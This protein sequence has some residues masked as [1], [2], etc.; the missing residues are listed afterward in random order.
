MA[1]KR[2]HIDVYG[3]VQGVGFRPFIYRIAH[4]Y[5]LV[6]WVLNHSL[7]VS[8]EVQGAKN[9]IDNFI[10]A[11]TQESPP[12]SQV[13]DVAF[14]EL[15][16]FSSHDIIEQYQHKFSI[17]QSQHSGFDDNNA[18]PKLSTHIPADFGL[19]QACLNDIQDVKSRYYRY[20]FTNCT[21]CGPRLSIIKKLPYDRKQTSM[22]SFT[23][24]ETCQTAYD[25]PLDRRYHAQPVACPQCGPQINWVTLNSNTADELKTDQESVFTY[26]VEAIESG[27]VVA[28]KGIGGFHLVCDAT[29]STAVDTLRKIK[30]RPKK[31]LAVMVKDSQQAQR[32]VTINEGELTLLES[33]ERPIVLLG[34]VS[35]SLDSLDLVKAEM[36]GNIAENVPYLGVMLPYTPLHYL[37]FDYL[38]KPLVFTSAN[39]SN[40]PILA[41]GCDVI[42]AFG[43]QLAGIIDHSRQIINACD[44][45]VVHFAGEQRQMLRLGRGYAP[46]YFSLP[47]HLHRPTLAVGAQQKVTFALAA[48]NQAMV[49]PYIGDLSNIEMQQFFQDQVTDLTEL[50]QINVAHYVCDK[51]PRYVTHQWAKEQETGQKHQIETIQH[52]HAHVLSVMAEYQLKEPVLGFSFDGTGLGDND[53]LWGG[54]VLIADTQRYQHCASLKPFRLISGE[55]AIK[56]PARL[57]FSLLLEYFEFEQIQAMHLAV[58]EQLKPNQLENWHILWKKGINSPYTSSMGRFIDAYCALLT[59]LDTVH[60]EGESGL[61]LEQLVLNGSADNIADQSTNPT[62]ALFKLDSS[63]LTRSQI[64]FYPLL[65]KALSYIS[66]D[67]IRVEESPIDM[68][69]QSTLAKLLFAQLADLVMTLSKQHPQIPVVLSGGVFQNRVLMD[70]IAKTFKAENRNYYASKTLPLNDGGICAGQLWYAAHQSQLIK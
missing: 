46:Y 66:P 9:D 18:E 39:H 57:L 35:Q 59:G 38:D 6:G 44:D 63:G 33:K 68:V 8:I 42:A 22:A 52:H 24:C 50:H 67:Q 10:T 37:L 4:Q 25:D 14:R 41:Q 65:K 29:N 58:F 28:I 13:D 53:E 55:Q 26:A 16:V 31:P 51:H 62:S 61:L 64:D 69:V 43:S 1:I 32:Y 47:S 34:K 30:H 17:H 20:P 70:T 15:S 27:E 19:C 48:G 11:I 40:Q 45:S 56:S 3:I 23:M 5:H 36:A 54:E 60:F 21:H 49:S 7:G 2:L 12:L